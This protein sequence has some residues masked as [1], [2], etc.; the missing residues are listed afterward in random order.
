MV[1]FSCKGGK[2]NF[3]L[4]VSKIRLRYGE[5]LQCLSHVPVTNF[6]NLFTHRL[7]NSVIRNV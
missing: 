4:V 3:R 5:H 2:V 1:T 7:T 6:V